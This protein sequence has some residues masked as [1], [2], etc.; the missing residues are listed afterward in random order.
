MRSIKVLTVL[1]FSF[2]FF[3]SGQE[4]RIYLDT[5]LEKH[6]GDIYVLFEETQKLAGE[7]GLQDLTK[8]KDT[9]S[10]RLW[11]PGAVLE[12][13]YD[14]T[15]KLKSQYINYIW[16]LN[17][18]GKKVSL[19]FKRNIF[20]IDSCK[21]IE[22]KLRTTNFV[23]LLHSDRSKWAY[24]TNGLFYEIE[25]ANKSHYRFNT[26]CQVRPP[27]PVYKH[28]DEYKTL[29]DVLLFI[30]N[31]INYWKYFNDFYSTQEP[32]KYTEGAGMRTKFTKY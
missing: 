8:S 9:F 10:I 5:T 11:Q 30:E 21:Q 27:D 14:S 24:K 20:S 32:G 16:K 2:H 4:K 26:F 15:G 23:D 17:K 19:L 22:D 6:W 25:L 29:Q 1:F 28:G 3:V 18:K 7:L 31:K 12:I 13:S